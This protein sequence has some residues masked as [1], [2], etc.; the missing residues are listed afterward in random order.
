MFVL[1]YRFYRDDA[2]KPR[3]EPYPTVSHIPGPAR[4]VCQWNKIAQGPLVCRWRPVGPSKEG[5]AR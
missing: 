3:R 4:L 5:A 1:A 2:D